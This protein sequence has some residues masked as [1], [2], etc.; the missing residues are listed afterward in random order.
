MNGRD[1]RRGH[2]APRIGFTL[3]ELLVVIV[4]IAVLASLILPAI[5]SSRRAA[6]RAECL[7]NIRQVGIALQNFGA[8]KT[9]GLPQLRTDTPYTN[10]AGD[11]GIIHTG[12]P[13]AIL[14][15]LD[16]KALYDNIL[17]NA[18]RTSAIASD[19][20]IAESEKVSIQVY[21]CPESGSYRKAGGLS[22]VING[23]FVLDAIWDQAHDEDSSIDWHCD[24]ATYPLYS[25]LSPEDLA[26]G[27][28]SGISFF[29]NSVS[30]DYVTA[31]DGTSSTLL[32]AEN[33]LA[34]PW[35]VTNLSQT[36]FAI[37]TITTREHCDPTIPLSQ[38][39][40]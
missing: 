33:L 22:Y 5:Q 9:E 29:N 15:V 12:W 7:N 27:L 4:I 34:G 2:M 23:G 16:N 1:H 14:P 28:A 8:S 32:L 35:Y 20:V 25:R 37:R 13:I 6:R 26:T 30:L 24:C 17:K 10:L 38:Y 11:Q 40:P 31:G 39:A 3:V 36:G 19:G 21:T 18:V